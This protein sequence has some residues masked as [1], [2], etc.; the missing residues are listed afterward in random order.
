MIT[1]ESIIDLLNN[2]KNSGRLIGSIKDRLKLLAQLEGLTA[3]DIH[4]DLTNNA[5]KLEKIVIAVSN[6]LGKPKYGF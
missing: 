5:V 2:L 1:I 4:K 3:D 6:I